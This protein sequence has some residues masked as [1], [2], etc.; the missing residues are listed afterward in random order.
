MKQC[1]EKGKHWFIRHLPHFKPLHYHK[2]D[3]VLISL[4][5]GSG[6][7]PEAQNI[8]GYIFQ[9][10]TGIEDL[11]GIGQCKDF[12]VLNYVCLFYFYCCYKLVLTQ[13]NLSFFFIK[14][15]V[16]NSNY[17]VPYSHILFTIAVECQNQLKILTQVSCFFSPAW[18]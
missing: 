15:L 11:I 17:L 13:P 6:S 9:G 14:P 12:L 2:K 1:S 3:G 10:L 16:L 7:F 5:K 8:P 18:Y 4:N